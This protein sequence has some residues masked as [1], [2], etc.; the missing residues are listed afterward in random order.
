MRLYR[1][2]GFRKRLVG[3]TR[4]STSLVKARQATPDYEQVKVSACEIDS[5]LTADDWIDLLEWDSPGLQ[6]PDRTPVDFFLSH[7]VVWSK[8][9]ESHGTG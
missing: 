7:E 4:W 3:E 8:G 2:Q 9:I 6:N 5:R 1:T